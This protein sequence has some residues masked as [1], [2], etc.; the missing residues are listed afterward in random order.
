MKIINDR[1][2]TV[3]QPWGDGDFIRANNPDCAGQFVCDCAFPCDEDADRDESASEIAAHIVQAHNWVLDLAYKQIP[4]DFLI[5]SCNRAI[6]NKALLTVTLGVTGDSNAMEIAE[7]QL[8]LIQQAV[9]LLKL[10]KDCEVV[11]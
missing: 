10:A 1:W 3:D 8:K 6:Q 2:Y 9:Q 5:E 11:A 7:K 4:L